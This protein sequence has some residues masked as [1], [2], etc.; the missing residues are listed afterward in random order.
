MSPLKTKYQFA[1]DL[2]LKAGDYIRQHLEDDVEIEEKTSPTD[3]VTVMDRLVQDRLVTAILKAYPKDTILAE[4]NGLTTDYKKGNTWII[5]PIDGTANFV[6]QKQDFAVMLAYFEEGVGRFGLI[7]DV[8]R[9]RLYHGGGDFPSQV[10]DRLLPHFDESQSLQHALI[11]SNAGMYRQNYMGIA[12]LVEHSLSL[13]VY[14]SAGIS[15]SNI[16]AGRLWGYF[17]TL[18]PWDYAAASILGKSLGYVVLTMTGKEPDFT[19]R[20]QIMMVPKSRL[21]DLQCY[22]KKEK[23]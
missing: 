18:Y 20:Q 16:L 3:L 1:K 14:G 7:Y 6:A 8:I 23:Q 2:V 11:A 21:C 15:F 4:E 19:S 5:D 12:D 10:N 13:R 22:M 9:D 17:S